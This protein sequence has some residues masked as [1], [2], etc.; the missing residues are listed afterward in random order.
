MP[1]IVLFILCNALRVFYTERH[2]KANLCNES[3]KANCT[4]QYEVGSLFDET[5]R[6]TVFWFL[7]MKF[8]SFSILKPFYVSKRLQ[9]TLFS[10]FTVTIIPIFCPSCH[11]I[12]SHIVRSYLFKSPN[13]SKL[14]KFKIERR[15]VH[16][17]EAS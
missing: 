7:R 8:F 2:V 12:A 11:L 10:F 16:P 15:W 9:A 6:H 13:Q 4:S 3:L 14:N 17:S 5:Y 1:R